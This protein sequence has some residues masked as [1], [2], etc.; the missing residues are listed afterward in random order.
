[1]TTDTILRERGMSVLVKNLGMVEAER[2]IMLMNR[3]PFDYT[4]WRVDLFENETVDEI[5]A[6]GQEYIE[7]LPISEESGHNC[8]IL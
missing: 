6:E 8:E 4:K 2:F 7:S 5:F 3:E 1:M